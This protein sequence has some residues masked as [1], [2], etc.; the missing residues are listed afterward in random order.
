MD[1][2]KSVF[3]TKGI[4]P[5][6]YINLDDQPER[7]EFMENQFNHWEIENYT[8]V[9]AYDG[10]EDD[11]SDI[12]KGRYPEMMSSG[13]ICLLYTSPSPRD[14]TLSRMPSSA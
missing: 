11:L 10:R 14:A 12:I 1:K 3:K 13:E 9:S 4:G 6:Y 5:I 7:R 8:R 2:N